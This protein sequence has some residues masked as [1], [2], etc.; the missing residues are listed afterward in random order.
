M[1]ADSD[2]AVP[3]VTCDA[4]YSGRLQLIQPATGHRSG[5]DAVLLAAAVPAKPITLCY[6]IGA[7]VGAVGLGIAVLR[8]AAE[9]VLVERDSA[10]VALAWANAEACG[11]S[12]SVAV[13]QCDVLDRVA[14]RQALPRRADLVVTNPPF[15]EAGRGRPSPDP[16]RRAAHVLDAG[17]AIGDWLSACL[18]R[19]ADRG[20]LVAIAAAA[21]L[22]DMLACLTGPTGGIV[23]K[24]V[25]PRAGNPALR[26][27]VR[28]VKGSR[29]PFEIAAPL[30]LHGDDGRFTLEAERLHRG[31]EPLA[32]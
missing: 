15:H 13:E 11:G 29:K 24:P 22:P 10:A 4:F 25:Q 20:A 19:L 27:L 9:I 21:V 14:L 26:V 30:V 2:D 8:P 17:F 28:A 16:I 5:T 31:D 3:A 1:A 6:D 18:D 32:W 7:G 23:V 12:A